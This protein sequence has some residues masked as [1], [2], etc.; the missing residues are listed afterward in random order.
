VTPIPTPPFQL[1]RRAAELLVGHPI[2]R[3]VFAWPILGHR[4]LVALD[5]PKRKIGSI[6]I[7]PS[8]Q[9]FA[10]RGHVIAVGE[11]VGTKWHPASG[12]ATGWWPITLSLPHLPA[13][14][15][16]ADF[17]RAATPRPI[18]GGET[19]AV[20]TSAGWFMVD[21]EEAAIGGTNGSPIT[22]CPHCKRTTRHNRY[23]QR[24]ESR[25]APWTLLGVRVL[26][27]SY[28][29]EA[30]VFEPDIDLDE[31][32]DWVEALKESGTD[33]LEWW[34]SP[35]KTLTDGDLQYY[36][37]RTLFVGEPKPEVEED[38]DALGLLYT[39]KGEA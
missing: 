6:E 7:P 9:K 10:A 25:P 38:V 18:V 12:E 11:L 30:L 23:E 14:W 20:L 22:E 39:P 15:C 3:E 27:G 37:G 16:C 4:I 1:P 32:K 28:A 2:S 33:S 26:F 13:V 8:S 36:D 29:G 19:Y 5:P 21:W 35:Y 17:H 24:A 34:K 31:G